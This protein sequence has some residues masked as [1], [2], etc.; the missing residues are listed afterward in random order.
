MLL[1]DIFVS[2]MLQEL[3]NVASRM[4]QEMLDIEQ[5]GN[6]PNGCDSHITGKFSGRHVAFTLPALSTLCMLLVV[7]QTRTACVLFLART[8]F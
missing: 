8:A 6:T 5:E 7:P 4:S 3:L 1:L 2:R